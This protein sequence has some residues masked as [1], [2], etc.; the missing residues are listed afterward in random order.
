MNASPT[1]VSA[2]N[3]CFVV[4]K[5]TLLKEVSFSITPGSWMAVVG[6]NGAGKTTLLDLVMGFKKP[7]SGKITVFSS[8]PFL[9]RAEDRQ[10][11]SYLS[12][13][14]DIPGDWSV[15]EFLEFNRRFYP[16]YDLALEKELCKT[17]R[18]NGVDRVGNLSA[19]EIRR[20]Q[21][22]AAL[23]FKPQLIVIDEITAVLDIVGR[24]QFIRYSA[25]R[26]PTG[27]PLYSRQIFWK[28]F[29]KK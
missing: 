28:D 2:E 25:S 17:F 18:V 7:T 19:G 24:R 22:V 20:A 12:E 23:S 9:D 26:E 21:I 10:K 8:E 11:I 6:E 27:L 5:K 16:T 15:G 1:L 14:V 13:K 29:T 3:L 4:R